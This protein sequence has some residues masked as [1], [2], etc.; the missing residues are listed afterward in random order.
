MNVARAQAGFQPV[1]W[2]IRRGNRHGSISAAGTAAETRFHENIF[3]VI[4][5]IPRP[6]LTPKTR[7]E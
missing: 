4:H 2:R 7:S 6:P 1:W 5:K 3:E